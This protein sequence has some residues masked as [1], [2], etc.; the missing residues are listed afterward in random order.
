MK[1]P[2]PLGL[3]NGSVRAMLALVLLGTCSFLWA[4]SQ[5]VPPE[6]QN[7]T[8]IVMVFY[9]LTR[10]KVPAPEPELPEPYVG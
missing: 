4:T 7:M 10:D 6:L 1:I 5:V 3:P 9:F 8:G 2:Q